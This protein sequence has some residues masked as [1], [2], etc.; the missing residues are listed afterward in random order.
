MR[1]LGIDLA[2]SEKR[3]TGVAYLEDGKLQCHLLYKDEEILELSK[4][5]SHVFMDAPL[6]IPKG[7]KT[8][9]DRK[10]PHLRECDVMLRRRGIR[11]FP[12]TLGPMRVL[13][14]RAMRLK[15]VLESMGKLVYEVFPGAFYDVMGVGRKDKKGIRELYK[16]LGFCMEEKSY[17]QDELDAVACLLT[18]LMFL[19]GRAELLGGED[20][21]IIVPKR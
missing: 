19:E 8:L 3:A 15:D 21:A 11:F 6:S 7:R 1:A 9:E 2:G 5:F 18:G 12:I 14:E 20:G 10:G 16:N 13:T 4:G 17:T